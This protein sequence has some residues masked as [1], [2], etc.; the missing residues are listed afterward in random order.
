MN[1][2]QVALAGVVDS[3]A[4]ALD[5]HREV[6]AAAIFGLGFFWNLSVVPQNEVTP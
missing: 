4:A 3:A 1:C 6:A 5:S 2:S